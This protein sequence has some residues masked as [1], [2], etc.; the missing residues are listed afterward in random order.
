MAYE[1]ETPQQPRSVQMGAIL[2]ALVGAISV[3]RVG[4]GVV[5][6]LRQDDWDAG[7]RAIFL[8]LNSIVLVVALFILL[9]AYHVGRGRMWAW[10]TSLVILPFTILFGGLLLLITVLGGAIPLAGTGVVAASL[11]AIV[12]LIV[13]RGYFLRRPAYPAYPPQPVYPPVS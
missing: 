11:A 7:A 4:F 12:T 8:V 6:N 3:A 5:S 2:L 1:V 9:L 13:A 10:I